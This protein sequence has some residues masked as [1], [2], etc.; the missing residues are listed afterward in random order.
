[1]ASIYDRADIYDLIEDDSRREIYRKH[2]ETIGNG[3]NIKSLLDISIGSG[4]VTL[5]AADLG[6]RLSG[7]DLSKAMLE[8][9]QKKAEAGKIDIEL[10]CCDFRSVSGQFAE[11]FDCVAST[12]NS[13]PYVNNEEVLLT[14]EQMDQLVKKACK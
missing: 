8:R 3:R 2:W 9:C 11:K 1:M 14:M 13:L 12:G 7:S 10:K 4:N 5:P 6:V